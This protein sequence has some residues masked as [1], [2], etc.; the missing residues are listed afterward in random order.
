MENFFYEDNFCSDLEDLMSNFDLYNKEDVEG[1]PDDWSINVMGTKPEK[2][3]V[4]KERFFDD[5]A[6]WLCDSYEERFPEDPDRKIG[7]IKAAL[8][9]CVDINKLNGLIPE[10]HYPADNE[11]KI[12]KSDL[13]NFIS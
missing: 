3:F 7:E 9:Q 8:M 5:L 12:T 2:M 4:L 1:L 10:L 6:D 11:F 13:L